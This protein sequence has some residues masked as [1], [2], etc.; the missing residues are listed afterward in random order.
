MRLTRERLYFCLMLVA[1]IACGV[2]AVRAPELAR[3]SFPP[4]VW[5]LAVSLMLDL[6]MMRLP[7]S[8]GLET[9]AMPWRIGSFIGAALLYLL[10]VQ[11][12][13]SLP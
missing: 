5:I 2:I 1:G 11:L 6:V 9:I 4:L 10:I 7:G 12:T 13:S 8:K 3:G